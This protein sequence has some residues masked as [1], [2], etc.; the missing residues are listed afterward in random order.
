M[1]KMIKLMIIIPLLLIL[2][3]GFSGGT[4]IALRAAAA[5]P[6][7]FRFLF[8]SQNICAHLRPDKAFEE[9]YPPFTLLKDIYRKYLREKGLKKRKDEKIL[10][11][12]LK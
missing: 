7:Y 6:D 11:I 5:H 1:K 10:K 12:L 4:L 8:G 9:D 3:M 2:I